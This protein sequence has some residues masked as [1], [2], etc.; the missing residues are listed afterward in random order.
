MLKP[1]DNL[2]LWLDDEN[3]G[4]GISQE[5]IRYTNLKHP[6]R[7]CAAVEN[8]HP[9]PFESEIIDAATQRVER[10]MLGLR[11]NKGVSHE[12]MP[13]GKL[14]KLEERGWIGRDDQRVWLTAE[15]RHF[16]SE[17]ALELI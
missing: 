11:L 14:A 6:E 13:Q 16:C 8:N 1:L 15:G 5:L 2:Q 12:G 7:Y 3:Q 17:V 4:F 10:I 9:I